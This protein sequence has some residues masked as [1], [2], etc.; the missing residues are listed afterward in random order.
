MNKVLG[1]LGLANRAGKLRNGH[2]VTDLVR[3]NQAKV[4]LY[5]SDASDRTKKQIS[6]KC[7]YY[8][9]PCYEFLDSE[10]ISAAIGGQNMKIVAVTDASFASAIVGE[11][12]RTEVD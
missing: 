1:Y 3:R 6:D 11:L 7:S 2:V 8:R 10:T 9:V 5:A 12:E 4:V